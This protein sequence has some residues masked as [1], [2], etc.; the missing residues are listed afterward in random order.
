M[1]RTKVNDVF[2]KENWKEYDRY[3]DSLKEKLVKSELPEVEQEKMFNQLA[4][5]MQMVMCANRIVDEANELIA[6]QKKLN[7]QYVKE[8]DD[9]KA[10]EIAEKHQ[11]LQEKIDEL[12]KER[13][14]FLNKYYSSK[15]KAQ[16][17]ENKL[18]EILTKKGYKLESKKFKSERI[19][20]NK[21]LETN[22][23]PAK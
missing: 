7:D 21:A 15:A 16:E 9:A 1:A 22:R 4:Y 23:S 17:Y 11:K 3:V 14:Y 5:N 12:K 6:Q 13:S 2:T 20:T 8:P 10:R 19:S 18:N